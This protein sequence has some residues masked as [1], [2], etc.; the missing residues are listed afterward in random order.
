LSAD[1]IPVGM[2][3]TEVMLQAAAADAPRRRR[4]PVLE[5]LN[6]ESMTYHSIESMQD[7]S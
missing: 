2:T 1:Q 6:G 3:A 7:A 4:H 5:M